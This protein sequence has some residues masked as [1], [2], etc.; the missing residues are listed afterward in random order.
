MERKVSEELL[1][2]KVDGYSKPILLYG[3]SGCGKTYSALSFGKSEYKNTVY[4]D[5]NDNLELN[6]VL[7]KNTTIDKLIR[8]L[9]AIS[10]ETIFKKETLIIFDNISERVLKGISPLFK[11]PSYHIIMI[12]D[13]FSLIDLCKGKNIALKKMQLVTFFEYLKY[14]GKEQL[15]VFIEDSFKTNKPMPF[16]TLAMEYY[17]D[18]VICGGYPRAIIEYNSGSSYNL[19]SSIHENNIILIKNKLFSLNSLIE[20]KRSNEIFNS[21]CIQLLKS[22]RKFLYGL[23]KG[24]ARSKDYSSSLDFMENNNII[25]KSTRL[26]DIVSPLSKGKDLESFKLYYNDSGILYKKLN[27]NRTRLLTNDKLMLTLYENNIAN[28]L[29]FNGFNIYHYQSEGKA[30]VDFVIQTKN[31][32]II[33]I[34]IISSENTKSKSLSLT[35][36]KYSLSF[37]IRLTNGNFDMKN[38]IKYIPYYASSCINKGI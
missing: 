18:Y 38:G 2:W 24:G 36:K 8:G 35:M 4:F 14:I 20:M 13:D 6:Y 33:P 34:E 1:K 30:F 12:T 22:N 23:I 28:S 17:N 25:I 21:I 37:A 27:V 11:D 10:L 16:H 5:C 31:G 15:I 3:I 29:V 19:L 32:K 26:S 9:S 7:D